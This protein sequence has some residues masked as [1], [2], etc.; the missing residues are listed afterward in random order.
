MI[1]PE[2]EQA[3]RLKVLFLTTWYPVNENPVGGIFVREHAKA[4]RFYDDVTILHL[5]GVDASLRKL[6]QMDREA[7]SSLSEGIPTYRL[8]HRR[9]RLAH[10][11][12]LIDVFS[13]IQAFRRLRRLEFTPDILHAHI[14]RAGFPAVLIGKLYRIPVV[15]TEQNSAF[16]R[17]LL[18]NADIRLARYSFSRADAVLP[19]S[20]ALQEGIQSYHIEA[21]WHIVPNSVD[22][23][24]FH[25]RVFLHKD[26]IYL[27]FVGGLTPVKGL[28]V[29]FQA[30]SLLS[31]RND[32]QL[33]IVGDGPESESYKAQVQILGLSDR[34]MFHGVKTKK[35][36]SSIMRQ[37]DLFVLPSLW[38]NMPCVLVEAMASGLPVVSTQTGGIP[39]IVSAETGLLAPPGDEKGLAETLN[40]AFDQIDRFD[41]G[42]I[43]QIAQQYS[44]QEVG[45]RIDAIYR[46][47]IRKSVHGLPA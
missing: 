41:R 30:L 36:I 28:P 19:V 11:T 6:W 7:D 45:R 14:H 31:Y 38:D 37:A 18:R 34:I 17:R 16:P 15:I 2:H 29:L 20:R 1:H 5:K 24:L 3:R 21:N 43:A 13:A 9:S 12:I 8:R 44:F 46:E 35:E 22:T 32:W 39:E 23:E 42:K 25:P 27:L 10:T 4:V 40:L 26:K 33:E 47:I